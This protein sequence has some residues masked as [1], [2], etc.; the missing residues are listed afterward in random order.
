MA[1]LGGKLDEIG[2]GIGSVV[3]VC[4]EAGMGK[5]RLMEEVARQAETRDLLFLRGAGD[6]RRLGL[7]YGLF[8]EV[9]SAYLE[10]GRAGERDV[11]QEFVASL[12]P[13]LWDSLFPGSKV[14]AAFQQVELRPE[15]CQSLFLAR[16]GRL[17]LELSQR[18]PLVL[19]LENLELA[20]SASLQMLRYLATHNA[21]A[22]MLILGT[23]EL[24]RGKGESATSLKP[25]VQELQRHA[26]VKLLDLKPLDLKG[27]LA[28]VAAVFGQNRFSDGM[29]QMIHS[30]NGGVP[31]FVLQYLESLRDNKVVYEKSGLWVS[32]E[33]E[34][35][36]EPTSIHAILRQRLGGLSEEERQVLGHAAVQGDAFT[37]RQ[38]ARTLGWPLAQVLRILSRLLR[39][40]RLLRV[41]EDK[42]RFVHALLSEVCYDFLPQREQQQAHL[43][44]ADTLSRGSQAEP[45]ALAYHFYR[46]GAFEKALGHLLEAGRRGRAAFAYEEARRFLEQG[47]EA[48]AA[49]GVA[50]H[51]EELQE[52]LLLLAEIE[53]R[54]GEP[55]EALA[56]CR[57]AIEEASPDQDGKV[58]ARSLMQ[59]GWIQY[60][61]GDWEDCSRLYR[62][63]LELFV[64]QGEEEG[65]GAIHVRLG[66]IA[67]ERGELEEAENCFQEAKETAIQS[68]N[69]PL[70]GSIYGNLGVI[71]SV[72][73]QHVEAVLSYSEA[74]KAY[75]RV[76]H[77]Y[78]LCQ[79][80]HN[81]GMA[82]AN[83]EEWKDALKWYADGEKLAREM[84]TVD[85]EANIL[86]ARAQAEVATGDLDGAEQT[87][88]KALS[89]ME[90]LGDR[91]G[92]AEC[93]KVEGSIWRERGEF[94]RAEASLQRGRH[95]CQE[96]ENRL[97]VAECDLELGRLEQARGN[98]DAA[99]L[100]L[101]E[102]K[103]AF[104][105][106]GAEEDAQ[107]AEGLLT[108]LAS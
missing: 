29:L 10:G 17:L 107:R 9:L 48:V 61:R 28:L 52:I 39:R 92:V 101:E 81:L 56:L 14:P 89:Y 4:S 108:Q 102:S 88:N 98:L 34:K 19:C 100:R 60:R 65:L 42:F 45:E 8:V 105:A 95:L 22:A 79:T 62:E 103:E 26:H 70:L 99:R 68:A 30:K 72:R 78:G 58:V 74:I 15:L 51:R 35:S 104:R 43:R 18:R 90:Q 13:H 32:D 37:G 21:E 83:Q 63:A 54:M 91:L 67:F 69:Y 33:I 73:G 40:T 66:N 23:G 6:A 16:L 50:E 44:L 85:V 25:L 31:L 82:H 71:A 57:R 38:A 53:D 106:L 86:V 55:D 87:C 84:G 3:F 36:P 64:A 2:Q 7:A 97:G 94:D 12:A 11:V 1:L 80:F 47:R 75:R 46:A 93:R 20:D 76:G 27:T 59:M 41:E 5:K 77:Q 96:L 49:L 24:E